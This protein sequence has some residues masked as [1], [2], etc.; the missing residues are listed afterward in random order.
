MQPIIAFKSERDPVSFPL[1]FPTASDLLSRES[2]MKFDF[3]SYKKQQ[4]QQLDGNEKIGRPNS[5]ISSVSCSSASTD[6][7]CQPRV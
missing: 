1:S 6:T 3:S 7:V 2:V 4:Q 5:S